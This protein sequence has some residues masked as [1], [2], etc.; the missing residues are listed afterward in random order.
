MRMRVEELAVQADVSVDT[1]RFYQKQ[2]LLPPPERDGRVAWYGE[3]HRERMGRI[4]ELQ[5]RGFSLAVIR[6]FLAGELDPAD[7][8]LAAAVVEAGTTAAGDDELIDLAELSVR[9]AVP[10]PLLEALVR[11]GLLVPRRHDDGPRYTGADVA[12]VAAG[13]RLVEAGL[14]L[15]ELFALARRHHALT[16][17][18]ATHAVE[19]FDTHIRKPLRDSDLPEAEKA[20]RLVDAF[21]VLMPEVTA[22]VTDHFRRIL[23]EV[24]QEHLEA[25]GEPDEIAAAGIEPTPIEAGRAPG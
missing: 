5:R 8:H 4:R 11:E 16:R 22:L 3:A 10:P 15:P 9:T 14:P 24:A 7:E 17:E 18:F 21:R 20:E 25:V 12:T 1:I 23:L 6:R 19:L 2:G 13:L